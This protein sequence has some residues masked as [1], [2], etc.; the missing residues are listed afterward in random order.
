MFSIYNGVGAVSRTF[1]KS[2]SRPRTVAHIVKS[3]SVA[4]LL[5][6]KSRFVYLGDAAGL[7]LVHQSAENDAAFQA[8][9]R[10]WKIKKQVQNDL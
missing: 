10:V 7:H 4:H 3:L 6:G 8:L 9:L 5:K 1:C 2:E